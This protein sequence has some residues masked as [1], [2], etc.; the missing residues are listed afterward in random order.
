M[1]SDGMALLVVIGML[2]FFGWLIAAQFPP[3]NRRHTPTSGRRTEDG[4]YDAILDDPHGV[5]D[6]HI[7]VIEKELAREGL[8]EVGRKRLEAMR[9][10]FVST[11]DEMRLLRDG[12]PDA[13][14]RFLDDGPMGRIDK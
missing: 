11:R 9:D 12:D 4:R 10:D 5:I 1:S 6:G 3:P 2:I 8:G 7:E 14:Q 13:V